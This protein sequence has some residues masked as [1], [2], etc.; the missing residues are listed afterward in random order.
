MVKLTA[1]Q[2]RV[3]DFIVAHHTRTGGGTNNRAIGEA[4]GHGDTH[5]NGAFNIVCR[6]VELGLV[7][8][9][10][11]E[12]GRAISNG[13]VPK[14]RNNLLIHVA[15]GENSRIGEN[16][17]VNICGLFVAFMIFADGKMIES[18]LYPIENA[19]KMADQ[20]KAPADLAVIDRLELVA[21][22]TAKRRISAKMAAAE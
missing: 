19:V 6:L 12:N 21:K 15:S 8:K 1:S 16:Y 11:A 2:Q 13:I 3:Y 18:G 17:T 20:I 22:F 7:E 10:K 5:G 14:T 4:C 9:L